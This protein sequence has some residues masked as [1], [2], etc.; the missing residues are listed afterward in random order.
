MWQLKVKRFWALIPTFA[1]VTGKKLIEGGGRLKTIHLIS[2]TFLSFF[3]DQDGKVLLKVINENLPFK[4][5]SSFLC[6]K[7]Q[8]GT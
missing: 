5:E 7:I 8:N 2:S 4:L 6:Y 3:Y 1:E